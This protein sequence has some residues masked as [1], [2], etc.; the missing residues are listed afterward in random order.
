M[1]CREFCFGVRGYCH[2]RALLYSRY[3]ENQFIKLYCI[4][5]SVVIIGVN[6]NTC[7][8]NMNLYNYI[9]QR[10]PFGLVFVGDVIVCVFWKG[11]RPKVGSWKFITTAFCVAENAS[12]FNE[13]LASVVVDDLFSAGYPVH[14]FHG[15]A[16]VYLG[17]GGYNKNGTRF[18]FQNLQ[19]KKRSKFNAFP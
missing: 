9:Q 15:S 11:L 6:C 4:C 10:K 18:R 12:V 19:T 13:T 8:Q 3:Q 16:R 2:A 5:N 14:G 1:A 17:W 7:K